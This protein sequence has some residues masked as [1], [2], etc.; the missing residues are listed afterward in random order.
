M[1]ASSEVLRSGQQRSSAGAASAPTYDV[2]C[3][4]SR[5]RCDDARRRQDR[6][7]YSENPDRT[8]GLSPD[9]SKIGT[10]PAPNQRVSCPNPQ[11]DDV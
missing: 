9:C 4:T 2:P 6:C 1:I 11:P 10:A 8:H 5:R 3:G 7:E